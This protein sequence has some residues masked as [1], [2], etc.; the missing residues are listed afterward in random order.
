MD[1]K[2]AV[3]FVRGYIAS[4]EKNF[5]NDFY[6]QGYD[7]IDTFY[8]DDAIASI[9]NNAQAKTLIQAVHAVDKVAERHA[10]AADAVDASTPY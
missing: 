3:K 1:I 5:P 9:I 2:K 4:K 6:S 8:S 7:W 10:K